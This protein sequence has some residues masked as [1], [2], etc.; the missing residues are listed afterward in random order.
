[1]LPAIV[2]AQTYSLCNKLAS[3]LTEA[4]LK[5]QELDEQEANKNVN[6]KKEEKF[7]KYVLKQAEAM[8]KTI[9]SNDIAEMCD[10]EEEIDGLTKKSNAIDQKYTFFN[11]SYRIAEK[12]MNDEIDM[13][14]RRNLDLPNILYEAWRRG[15]GIH[16]EDFHFKC[17][18]LTEYFLRKHH[19]QV[20]FATD[21]LSMGIN[22]PCK[23]V[24]LLHDSLQYDSIKYRQVTLN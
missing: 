16:H 11:P 1:M 10:L 12:E 9:L 14:M 24:V 3:T 17:R 19:L 22:M 6:L 2:F 7:K 21:T 20:V 13:F 4:L 23:T 8:K 18:N 15:I 5:K